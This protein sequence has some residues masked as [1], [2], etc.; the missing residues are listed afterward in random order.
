MKKS[1]VVVTGVFDLIHTGHLRFF[2]AAKRLGH[3]L[4]VIVSCDE[5][6]MKEKRSPLNSQRE[7]KE[8]LEALRPVDQVVIGY[9]CRDKYK[10]IV[11]QNPDIFVL[12]YDQ[13]YDLKEIEKELIKR[14]CQAKVVRLEKYGEKSTTAMIKRAIS[15]ETL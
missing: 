3:K 15:M 11:D 10:I 14:G 5:V 13:P 1:K 7:R 9:D 2:Q 8:M 6:C 12:G 4:V